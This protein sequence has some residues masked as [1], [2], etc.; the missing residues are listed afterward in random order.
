MKQ[1]TLGILLFLFLCTQGCKTRAQQ[2]VYENIPAI[3]SEIE[4]ATKKNMS[5]WDKD[6]Y[7]AIF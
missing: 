7:G 2:N 3:F 1:T 6:L 4:V 5:L